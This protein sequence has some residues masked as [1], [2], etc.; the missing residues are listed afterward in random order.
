MITQF[1]IF[2]SLNSGEIE[3]GDY[4]ICE[5]LN[6]GFEPLNLFL[7]GAIGRIAHVEEEWKNYKYKVIY[8]E[9]PYFV[10]G[11]F[12]QIERALDSSYIKYVRYFKLDEIK[13]YSN[14]KQDLITHLKATQFDL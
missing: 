3:A 4:A 11:I 13:F 9:V 14:N 10:A 12:F 6:K 2:E 1:K 8:D 5:C 7:K